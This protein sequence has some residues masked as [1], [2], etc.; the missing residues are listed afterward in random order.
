MQAIYL[1]SVILNEQLLLFLYLP[2]SLVIIIARLHQVVLHPPHLMVPSSVSEMSETD[3]LM[4]SVYDEEHLRAA[5]LTLDQLFR[6][7]AQTT[8]GSSTTST[9]LSEFDEIKKSLENLPKIESHLEKK[10]EN[11]IAA[12]RKSVVIKINDPITKAPSKKDKKDLKDLDSGS[13]W[14]NMKKPEMTPE[15]KRDFMVLKNRAALD[16]KRHYKKEKWVTPKFFQTGTI[17]EGN[18]EFYSARLAKKNR[19]RTLAQEILNDTEKT[20][21]FKKKFYEIRDKKVSGGKKHYKSIQ[22]KRRGY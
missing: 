15:L 17:I 11:D 13:E 5:N 3:K 8:D 10:L 9:G 22:K 2:C 7:L 20:E 19:G 14:F 18:T 4:D 1:D 6:E 21:Y 12:G 16:P